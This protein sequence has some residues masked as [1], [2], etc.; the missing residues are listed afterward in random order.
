MQL[1][2]PQNQ[3]RVYL[4]LM[5][6]TALAIVGVVIFGMVL[7]SLHTSSN[8]PASASSTAAKEP[9]AESNYRVVYQKDAVVVKTDAA[10]FMPAGKNPG[11]CN[12]GSTRQVCVAAG[13][14][15]LAEL[16]KLQADMK[17]VPVPPRYADADKLLKQAVQA[18]IDGLTLRDQALT[19]ND[20]T[21]SIDPAN[22][23]LGEANNLFKKADQA[24]PADARPAPSLAS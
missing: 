14:K 22:A 16:K 24:F 9:L 19:S 10:A 15:V 1:S 13:E 3:S 4:G 8:Q 7:P 11:A 18:E 2:R 23:K 20:P 6:A 5:V 21:A 12:K 17:P